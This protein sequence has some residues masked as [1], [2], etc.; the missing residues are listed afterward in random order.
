MGG[1]G[2]RQRANV[3]DAGKL[4]PD[5]PATACPSQCGRAKVLEAASV[6]GAEFS[7]EAE[8]AGRERSIEAVEGYCDGLVHGSYS[9]GREG[10]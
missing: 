4:T 7:E 3:E 6:A 8:A 10:R 5:D 2:E 1:P 9:C